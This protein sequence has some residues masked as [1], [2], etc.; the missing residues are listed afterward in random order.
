M[1]RVGLTGNVAAGKSAVAGSLAGWGATLIDADEL[2]RAVQ[3]PGSPVLDAIAD[4][5][6]AAMVGPDGY[7][8]R[9]ALR[10]LV[11]R[12]DTARARLNDIVHHAVH[13]R[14]AAAE[15]DATARGDCIV[16]HDIPLLF[17]VLDPDDFDVIVLVDAPAA[18]RR[19]RL[20]ADRGL[21]PSDADRLIA[22]QLPAADKRD[23]SD[24]VIEND[25][26]LADLRDRTWNVWLDL[27]R[28][29]AAQAA[30]D[31]PPG[32]LVPDDGTP[33]ATV[34]ALVARARDAGMP[35]SRIR[36][37]ASA[38]TLE[39]PTV[40]LVSGPASDA[41]RT[42][43]VWSR[44]RPDAV[45]VWPCGDDDPARVARI[46]VRPWTAPDDTRE[47]GPGYVALAAATPRGAMVSDLSALVSAAG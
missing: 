27:R 5:F 16:V 46:D 42:A 25:R 33:S 9:A 15:T 11:M 10:T 31:R 22:A 23:R 39:G 45:V 38:P 34:D 37:D 8:D 24:H 32:V 12:D 18:E 14:R 35:V 41:R 1:L 47:P 6:G 30:G 17:E 36:P 20:V 7:L 2:V 29:G 26:S 19:R 21:D 40:F 44:A 3:V 4:A 13:E 43:D 28:R